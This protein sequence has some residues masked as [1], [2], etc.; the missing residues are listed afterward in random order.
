ARLALGIV[1]PSMDGPVVSVASGGA[2]GDGDVELSDALSLT[3]GRLERALVLAAGVAVEATAAKPVFP[4][5]EIQKRGVNDSL[6]VD[7]TLFNRGRVDVS[8]LH[9]RIDMIGSS[10]RLAETGMPE[11]RI[12]PDSAR[13]VVRHAIAYKPT[14][15]WWRGDTRVGDFFPSDINGMDEATRQAQTAVQARARIAIAGVPV[16]VVVPV[17]NR[18]ADPVKGDQQVP[19]A[20][21]PGITIAVGRPIEYIRAGV[22]VQRLFQARVLSAYPH[23]VDVEVKIQL[24]A[25]LKADSMQRDR[26]LTPEAP[27]V[28]LSF[29]ASGNVPEGR[30]QMG[31][32]AN[33][34]RISALTGYYTIDYDHITPQ[35]EYA[36]SGKWLAGVSVKLP[37][38]ARVGYVPGVGDLGIEA[39][40]QLDIPVEVLDRSAIGSGDLSRFSSIV[41][42]PRAYEANKWLPEVNRRLLD[43]AR[44]GGTLVVQYGQ[45]E[46]LQPGIMPYPIELKRPAERVTSENAP[47]TVLQPTAPLL[48]SPNRITPRDWGEWVQERAIYMPSTAAPQYRSLLQ[49]N[50]PEEPA[51]RNALLQADVGKGKYVYVTLSLFRQLPNGNPGAARLLLNM[52]AGEAP[53]TKPKM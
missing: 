23:P 30:L 8:L 19:V 28:A 29:V 16:D 47:V 12:M 18:F 22:P 26:T 45:Y 25:G 33:H 35:R 36:P 48:T 2:M 13:T 42:G 31:A 44:S 49:M 43:Y 20:A 52:I 9:A 27:M 46:M 7:I 24:P 17:V 53:A 14:T 3:I 10:R 40:E 15:S 1:A 32:I 41:V 51:N 21:V 37:P 6:P 4:V 34:Q 50:D 11:E 5:R 39:L 38:R